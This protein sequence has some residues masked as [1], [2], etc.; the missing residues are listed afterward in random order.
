LKRAFLVLTLVF[1]MVF[2]VF[3]P[4][5]SV[6]AQSSTF[7]ISA[8][9]TP[10]TLS[11]EEFTDLSITATNIGEKSVIN[12]AV[13]V[14]DIDYE[15]KT[16]LNG[17]FEIV[18]WY[19][20]WW[21][22]TLPPGGTLECGKVLK[23][24]KTGTYTITVSV[25]WQAGYGEEEQSKEAD[26]TVYVEEAPKPDLTVTDISWTPSE[27]AEGDTITFTVYIK[28]QG[29]TSSSSCIIKYYIDSS[30]LDS[31]LVV[32]L[33]AGESTT[34]I[35]SWTAPSGSA[36]NHTV[37]AVVDADNQVSE[38][39]ENNN[40]RSETFTV[41][42]I[43]VEIYIEK[44]ENIVAGDE[45]KRLFRDFI[46]WIPG[47]SL[48]LI[49]DKVFFKVMSAADVEKL[50][51]KL[52][53]E[54]SGIDFPA[55]VVATKVYENTFVANIGVTRSYSIEEQKH[56]VVLFVFELVA[57]KVV[58]LLEGLVRL[59]V[60]EILGW[61][62]DE[63]SKGEPLVDV[64]V[65]I[66]EVVPVLKDGTELESKLFSYRLE[67]V[68]QGIAKEDPNSLVK[69][70]E[71][72]ILD[73][74]ASESNVLV[75]TSSGARVGALFENGVFRDVNEVPGAYYSGSGTHPQI[76]IL[77]YSEGVYKI[78]IYAMEAGDVHLYVWAKDAEEQT[79][80]MSEGEIQEHVVQISTDK[81]YVDAPW[82]VVWANQLLLGGVCTIVVAVVAGVFVL[83]RRRK[84][85]LTETTPPS[86]PLTYYCLSCGSELT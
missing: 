12:V 34:C 9:A 50:I 28:N 62:L 3:A 29:S 17:A 13:E 71:D 82:W 16:L 72:F 27:P 19:G 85:V 49:H 58:G 32:G 26:V 54:E 60:E 74:V 33:S 56:A 15:G 76:I 78:Q 70:V 59:I 22:D 14:F 21:A 10:N 4:I 53:S 67:T 80:S 1:L 20:E 43:P 81:V 75:T 79:F 45:I 84:H 24:L 6:Q 25:V 8:T 44:T 38:S 66:S 30:Y 37:K 46:D 47:T 69:I 5:T 36:G 40:E 55:E 42:S 77:P 68:A 2:P 61:V 48:P 73:L 41:T 31:D 18:S 23:A 11:V 52:R 35:F 7:S 51:V 86:A 39:N 57:G 65:Y 63:A 83:R 64:D